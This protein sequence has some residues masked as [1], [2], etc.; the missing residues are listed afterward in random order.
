M[1]DR[2]SGTQNTRNAQE[3]KNLMLFRALLHLKGFFL[4]H[5]I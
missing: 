2:L 1:H 4:K 5:E 3:K